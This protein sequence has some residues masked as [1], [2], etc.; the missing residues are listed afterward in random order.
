MKFIKLDSS[1]IKM[2]DH[3]AQTKPPSRIVY[4][5]FGVSLQRNDCL[6]CRVLIRRR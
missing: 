3:I 6:T 1:D 5:P 4:P 2:L